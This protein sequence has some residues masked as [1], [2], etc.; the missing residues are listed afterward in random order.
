MNQEELAAL[1]KL[2]SSIKYRAI[3][4]SFVVLI[5]PPLLVSVIG[6]AIT[7]SVVDSWADWYMV[8]LPYYVI[9]TIASLVFVRLWFL[10]TS[11]DNRSI[12]DKIEALIDAQ[13]EQQEQQESVDVNITTLFSQQKLYY[14]NAPVSANHYNTKLTHSNCEWIYPG[15]NNSK[16]ASVSEL[17]KRGYIVKN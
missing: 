9:A 3:I 1:K 8:S 17:N 14:N 7:D 5:S 12:Y 2:H 11:I 13:Q 10:D 4:S 16:M 6:K 15:A